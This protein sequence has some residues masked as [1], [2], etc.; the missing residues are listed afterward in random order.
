LTYVGRLN[1]NNYDNV[2]GVVITK[3][4]L[5]EFT[6]FTV[7]SGH[8]PSPLV[9]LTAK[10]EYMRTISERTIILIWLQLAASAHDY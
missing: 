7:P 6:R 3:E 10:A 1:T 5:R 9:L 8:S 4:S 2:Y